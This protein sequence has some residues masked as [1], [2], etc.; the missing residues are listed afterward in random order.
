MYLF[1]A[2]HNTS[3]ELRRDITSFVSGNEPQNLQ[4]F[5]LGTGKKLIT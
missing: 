3:N 5:I 1:R 2:G 4:N